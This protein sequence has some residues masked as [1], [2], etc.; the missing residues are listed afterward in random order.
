M[1]KQL[2]FFSLCFATASSLAMDMEYRKPWV[3]R[4]KFIKVSS[5]KINAK[6]PINHSTTVLDVKKQLE[7]NEGIPTEQQ[8]IE[9]IWPNLWTL[10]YMRYNSG[11]LFNDILIKD[12]MDFY[13]TN[14]F[15]L[16]LQ[17]RHET[18]AENN[19]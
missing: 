12:A 3:Q 19:N 2:L 4:A 5:M 1:F 11:P 17:L 14:T 6:I 7:K 18:P 8:S 13:N 9:A 15:R 10:G 16:W